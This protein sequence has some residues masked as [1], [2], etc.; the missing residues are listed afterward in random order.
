[1]NGSMNVRSVPSIPCGWKTRWSRTHSESKPE[2]V[3]QAGALDQQVLVGLE[4]EVGDEK[5]EP[6]HDWPSL[7]GSMRCLGCGLG[8]ALDRD[9]RAW[10][11]QPGLPTTS[12][13]A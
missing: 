2:A 8:D 10:R 11:P 1:M 6:G 3:G 12:P 9:G 5:A 13:S 7:L 4:A